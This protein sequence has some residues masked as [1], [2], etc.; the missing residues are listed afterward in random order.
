M[1]SR[2]EKRIDK[3]VG[4]GVEVGAGGEDEEKPGE[5]DTMG[6][7]IRTLLEESIYE[8]GGPKGEQTA[9]C[10]AF[11]GANFFFNSKCMS[12]LRACVE[13]GGGSLPW[14]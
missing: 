8:A 10:W 13:L 2:Q 11:G 4:V 1:R 7:R 9:C 14:C 5:S 6:H 3:E 12:L